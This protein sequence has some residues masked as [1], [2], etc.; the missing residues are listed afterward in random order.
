MRLAKLPVLV[1]ALALAAPA[2]ARAGLLLEGSAGLGVQ[3]SPSVERAPVNVMLAPGY[4]IDILGT[5]LKLELG[6]LGNLGDVRSS[7]FDLEL[8]PMVVLAPPI[9][10]LYLRG[11]VAV[12][13]LV[14]GPTNWAYGGA[15]GTSFSLFGLGVFIEAGVLPR[16]AKIDTTTNM[17][18]V[19]STPNPTKDEFRWFAEGRVGAFFEF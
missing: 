4:G 3:L 10:P 9:L 13:N 7:K 5:K 18:V 8:R 15:L 2:A 17:P 1:A 6:L 16:N 11:I 14:N 12:Q 19:G